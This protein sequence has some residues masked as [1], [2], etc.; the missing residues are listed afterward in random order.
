MRIVLIQIAGLLITSVLYCLIVPQAR[1]TVMG[2]GTLTDK[3]LY[4]GIRAV[5][6]YVCFLFV[7]FAFLSGGKKRPMPGKG[8]YG[9]YGDKPADDS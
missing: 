1:E 5:C 8:A 4:V 2:E 3:L 7:Y 9:D 6:I